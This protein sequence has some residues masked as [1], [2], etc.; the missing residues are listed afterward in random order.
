MTSINDFRQIV[1]VDEVLVFE[2]ELLRGVVRGDALAVDH[3]AD[4]PP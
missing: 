1:K 3:E 4:L 2:P